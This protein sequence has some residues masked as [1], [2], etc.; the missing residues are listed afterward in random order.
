M[1]NC[2]LWLPPSARMALGQADALKRD[3]QNVLMTASFG[4]VPSKEQSF[5]WEDDLK[6]CDY[7]LATRIFETIFCIFTN[8]AGE[9]KV[10]AATLSFPQLERDAE[11]RLG[12]MVQ[13][14][15]DNSSRLGGLAI[16]CSSWPKTPATMIQL[17]WPSSSSS[18]SSSYSI[19][20]NTNLIEYNLER[21]GVDPSSVASAIKATETWVGEKLCQLGLCPY[22]YSL[23]RAAVGLESVGVKEGPIVVRHASSGST[24]IPPST[25]G[26]TAAELPPAA[27]LTHAFW[28]GVSELVAKSEQEVA[29]FLIV[30]PRSYD[31]EFQEFAKTFD[32]LIEPLVK[33]TQAE[34]LVGRAI[35]H[36]RYDSTLIGH[37]Q[38][39]P[40]HAVPARM[41]EGFM[42]RYLLEDKDKS[43]KKPDLATIA[44]AND[45]V[46]WT[47]HATINLLRRSQLSAS[48][49]AEAASFNKR[50]NWIYARN[51]LRILKSG[52]LET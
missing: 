25:R 41:V 36:P 11:N 24:D 5:Y 39:L 34:T 12:Q 7:K 8:G 44:K 20:A 42:D 38:I 13:V 26:D 16:E 1:V 29:T 51:V 33:I 37:T 31:E 50:P 52:V 23:Q 32:Q 6:V 45:A 46:R 9:T 35:F 49:V 17:A 2:G 10:R 22:T 27:V 18:S 21:G 30:A 3:C 14:L 28:N 19:Q 4:V 47:P 48:K 43:T 15:T 40:G